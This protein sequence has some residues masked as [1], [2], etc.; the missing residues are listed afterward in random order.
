MT[1]S[2]T[3]AT[4]SPRLDIGAQPPHAVGPIVLI[5]NQPRADLWVR[6]ITM[7]GPLDL[8][9]A[10]LAVRADAPGYDPVH[11][12]EVDRLHLKVVTIIAPIALAGGQSR[13]LPLMTGRIDASNG[14]V[15]A[16]RDELT[17]AVRC[18]WQT[19]LDQRPNAEQI[20]QL[21]GASWILREFIEQL[22]ATGPL[23]LSTRLLS[24][25]RLARPVKLPSLRAATLGRLLEAVLSEQRL[26]IQRQLL[27]DGHR[28]SEQRALR[29]D[30][31]ARSVRLTLD[32]QANPAG[33]VESLRHAAPS[34]RPVKFVAQADGQRVEST[35]DLLPGWDASDES[36]ADA[37]YARSTSNDFD[38]V[39]NVFRLWVLNEDG[40]FDGA[41]FDLTT[42]F[43]EGRAIDPQAMRFEQ[44]L[45]RDS[46]G[47][48]VG[49]PVQYSLDGGASWSRW[50]GAA[51]V[52]RDRAG[53]Y[54]DDDAL[55]AG[56]LSAVRSG[57]GRVR[58]TASLQSPL[59]LQGVRWRGNPFA[60]A[61]DQ[62]RLDVSDRFAW[63]RVAPSSRF[64]NQIDSGERS[65]DIVDD[66]AAMMTW[67]AQY[68]GEQAAAGGRV[69]IQAV[70]PMLGLRLGDRLDQLS[71]LGIGAGLRDPASHA[72][73]ATLVKIQHRWDTAR[74]ELMWEAR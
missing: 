69:T 67:L 54:L 48:S 73:R 68:A 6:S 70:G 44:A 24:D 61:F 15:D 31:D 41:A 35:F 18:D 25:E 30:C 1:V 2:T 60:G 62:R 23:N 27:W 21:S 65:A 11:R 74:S 37:E 17:L 8:R 9:T 3:A 10:E 56:F 12:A 64:A 14:R 45:T 26:M 47:R 34:A 20:N 39:A 43:D 4:L 32:E 58:I 36:A 71:G 53:V 63:R 5:D 46:A 49:A 55:P 7:Q 13:L 50:P 33:A 19:L 29:A 28:V 51:V 66:R 59:P 38:A 72:P 16:R 52:L 57:D 40:A 22:G 42:F